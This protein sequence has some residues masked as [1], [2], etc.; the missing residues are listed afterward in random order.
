MNIQDA[1]DSIHAALLTIL[2]HSTLNERVHLTYRGKCI[3]H[4]YLD[5]S[6]KERQITFQNKERQRYV[7][8]K[9]AKQLRLLV[10]DGIDVKGQGS[11]VLQNGD[12][13]YVPKPLVPKYGNIL[14]FTPRKTF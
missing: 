11:I 12:V 1:M 6:G 7:T 9:L 13:V 4:P 14:F 3:L 8:R 5:D 2:E 10:R